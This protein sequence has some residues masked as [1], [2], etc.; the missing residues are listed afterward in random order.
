VGNGRLPGSPSMKGTVTLPAFSLYFIAALQTVAAKTGDQLLER[1]QNPQ[2]P[3][4]ETLLTD[5]LNAIAAMPEAFGLVLDDYHLVDAPQVDQAMAFILENLPPQ[6]H[7]VLTTREDPNFPLPRWRVRRQLTEL[8]AS[9]LRFTAAETA[10]FLS[11]VMG[12]NLA[13]DHI[14]MLEARTEGWIA[15][16]QLAALS[17]QGPERFVRASEWFEAN[18]RTL[19]AF[20]HAAAAYDV[21]RAAR[22][23]EG[24]GL[25]LYFRGEAAAVQ[26][27]LTSLPEA[28]FVARPSLW[29]TYASVLTMTGRL[30]ENIEERL[31][32]AETALPLAAGD[33]KTADLLGQIAAIRAMLAVPKNHVETI[34]TQSRRALEL[35]H[36]NNVPMRTTTTWT[37]GYA[38]QVQGDRQAARQAYGEAAA[39]AR[40]SDN[41]MITLA[42]LTNLGQVQESDLQLHQAAATYAE[43]VEL[44]DNLPWIMAYLP[45]VLLGLGRIHYQWN[46]LTAVATY[47]HQA[48]ELAGELEN[49]DTPAAAGILLARL[50]LAQNDLPAAQALLAETEQFIR[51]RQFDHWLGELTEVRI[52]VALRLGDHGTAGRLAGERPSPRNQ[53]RVALAQGDPAAALA[54]LEPAHQQAVAKAWADE[55]LQVRVLQALA[56]DAAGDCD[57]AVE[58]LGEALALA[59]PGGLLRPF[60][61]EGPPMARLL[62]EALT[63][64]IAPGFVRQL[65]AAFPAADAA[66]T[67]SPTVPEAEAGLVE[68]LSEREIEVLK[69]IAEGLT[70]Q[71]VANRLYLSLHTVK[72]HARNIYAKLGVKNR[73][74]AV[75]KG[76]ALGLLSPT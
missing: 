33:N 57:K 63:R 53:A 67:P 59:A 68:P 75:A 52:L 55:Q 41:V 73:T 71:E 24:D 36:P 17:M 20:Q 8:R 27:W 3:P 25:P 51:Q 23:I 50:R 43:L 34:L 11:Q 5:L 66:P 18:G 54:A 56:F 21:A 74:Q 22:L 6:M 15:G 4:P 45:V 37:L 13:E 31:Q 28:E 1:L 70:N 39:A 12:L 76:R 7:L 38:Y 9:D 26:Q 2:P 44:S 65:L 16:L 14:A 46:E 10:E 42:A 47:C 58:L 19:E 30:T 40:R 48:Q 49:V 61:D 62:Y 32:S 69:F 35:L 60:V 64:G 29:V 72:V